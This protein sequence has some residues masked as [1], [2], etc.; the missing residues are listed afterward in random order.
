MEAKLLEAD[1]AEHVLDAPYVG[2]RG[3]ELISWAL[4][5]GP[6]CVRDLGSRQVKYFAAICVRKGIEWPDGFFESDVD[7][8]L[9]RS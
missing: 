3:K 7:E 1:E 6:E 5:A 9:D 2:L 4:N 8:L